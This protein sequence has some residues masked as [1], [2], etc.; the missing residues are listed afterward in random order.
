MFLIKVESEFYNKTVKTV[1]TVKLPDANF[2]MLHLL[3]NLPSYFIRCADVKNF[4]LQC[5]RLKL[6]GNNVFVIFDYLSL[7]STHLCLDCWR[8][9][10]CAVSALCCSG[11]GSSFRPA[12]SK[13]TF[14][15]KSG[16]MQ[17]VRKHIWHFSSC[18]IFYLA[19]FCFFF[20]FPFAVKLKIE[21]EIFYQF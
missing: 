20:K 5:L 4:L 21:C 12:V 11:L 9:Q 17:T 8:W 13:F 14:V 16:L 2:L 19:V 1:V 3:L 18:I 10:S 6:R 15:L 7:V